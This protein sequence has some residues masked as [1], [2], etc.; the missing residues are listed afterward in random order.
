MKT[1]FQF[2]CLYAALYLFSGYDTV[3]INGIRLADGDGTYQ[4]R[5]E[6][7]IDGVWGTVCDNN[8]DM[9]DAIVMCRM[10]NFSATSFHTGSH[11]GEGVGPVF[12]REFHCRGYESTLQ[13]CTFV[14]NEF[15]CS[16][17]R[18]VGITCTECGEITIA[19]GQVVSVFANGT[20]VTAR[21]D[22]G[23]VSGTYISHCD[24]N[25]K[26][27][28]ITCLPIGYP[29]NI[30][31]IRLV[32]GIGLFDGRVEI[33]INNTWGTVCSY[34][35]RNNEASA[36]CRILGYEGYRRYYT[37]AYTY[38]EGV[39]PIFVTELDCP[40]RATDFNNCTY[41]VN[42]SCTHYSDVAVACTDTPLNITN[43]RLVNGNG[44]YDG[45][46]E[47]MANGVWGTVCSRYVGEEEATTF[48]LMMNRSLGMY[49]RSTVLAAESLPVLIGNMHCS[50][51]KDHINDC[52]YYS[53]DKLYC[54]QSNALSL[55][56]LP[57]S[58]DFMH[59]SITAFD[60]TN[61]TIT[62]DDGYEPEKTYVQCLENGHVIYDKVCTSI[63]SYPLDISSF[64]R[65]GN[66]IE[67]MVEGEWGTICYD[68][69]DSNDGHVIC[70]M[71]GENY[72]SHTRGG[73]GNGPIFIQNLMCTGS[74]SHISEC[75]YNVP[76]NCTHK[77]DVEVVCTDYPLNIS[78]I[79]LA[80]TV[81]GRQ[82][83]VEIEVGGVW[84]TVC[85]DDFSRNDALVI[86]RMLGLN[87]SYSHAHYFGN[88]HYGPGNGTIF[89]DDLSCSGDEYHINDCSYLPEHNCAHNED[90]SVIC[91]ED[92]NVTDARLLNG[93]GPFDGRAEI[94]INDIWGTIC[95]HNFELLQANAFCSILGKR[96]TQR[97]T[98][99]RYG[100]GSGIIYDVSCL[101]M[102]I[103][104]CRFEIADRCTH[105]RDASVV[106]NDCGEPEISH[107]GVDYFTYNGSTLYADCSYYKSYVGTL[108]LLC[109]NDTDQWETVGAC[110]EYSFPLDITGVRL[111]GGESISR[112]R[113]EI[114]SMDTWGTICD[115]SFG[116][117]EADVICS[118]VG[119]PPAVMYYTSAYYGE[120]TGPIFVDELNCGENTS[121]I[122]NCTYNTYDS[123]GHAD[124]IS[125][126]C[127]ECE[128]LEVD[129]GFINSTVNRYGDAVEVSCARDH[130]LNGNSVIICNSDG[131]W[132]DYPTCS[133]I[134]C[135]DP[136]PDHG[137]SNASTTLNGTVVSVECYE[138]YSTVGD[139]IISC[140]ENETWTDETGCEIKDCGYPSVSYAEVTLP[141]NKTTYGETARLSCWT[142]YALTGNPAV[143]CLS[144]GSWEIMPTC[145]IVDCG[146]P[147]P[148]KGSSDKNETTFGTVVKVT[149]DPG[150]NI[151]G[152]STI[153][154]QDDGTWSDNPVCDA[155]DCGLL[156]VPNGKVNDSQGTTIGSV[157][158][159]TCDEGYNIKGTSFATCMDTGTRAYWNFT[160][161]CEIQVCQDPTPDNGRISKTDGNI[162]YVF[163][164]YAEIECNTGY[165]VHG[166]NVI[167]CE[168]DGEWSDNTTCVIFDC[169]SL[170]APLHG[171]MAD[172]QGTKYHAEIRFSCNEDFL[173]LGE[174][175]TVCEETGEW[176][177]ETP[178]CVAK[179]DVGDTCIHKDYCLLADSQCINSVC[180]CITGIYDSRT[181]KCDTMP[182]MPFGEKEGDT[183]VSNRTDCS[184][185]VSFEPRFPIFDQMHTDLYVC[186]YGL[187]SFD[188]PF[189]NPTP[190]ANKQ[191]L[192][193]LGL[194][195]TILAPFYGPIDNKKSGPVWFR[196]YNILNSHRKME[197]HSDLISYIE[198]I[199]KKFEDLPSY[200]ASFVLI[201]TWYQAKAVGSGYDKT[202]SST[203]Q[204]VLTSDGKTTYAFYIYGNGMMQWVNN[205]STDL[206]VWVGY[207][208][209][210]LTNT[211]PYSFTD[212]ALQL[213]LK[214]TIS[215]SEKDVAGLIFRPL[216]SQGKQRDNHAVDCIRWY[217]ENYKEKKRLDYVASLIPDCPCDIRLSRFDP[218]FWRIGLYR[219]RQDLKY[220]C[221]DMLHVGNLGH[222]GKSCCYD[223][224][225]WLWVYERPLAGS[226][227]LFNRHH[228]L[229]HKINDVQP[230]TKCCVLSKYCN[231]YYDLRPTGSCYR[232][233]PYNFG[234]FWG[235][236]HFSTLDGMNFTFNG[237]G[238]YTLL[239]IETENCSFDLQ[240]RTERAIKGNGNL[241]DA[242]VFTAFAA[243]DSHNSSAHIERN[244]ERTGINLY[245]NKV[246]L[247]DK[248]NSNTNE[249]DPFTWSSK[250][251]KLVISKQ[252]GSVNVFFPACNVSLIIAIG[253]EM[254]SLSTFV[255]EKFK[256]QTKGLLGNYN[257]D[258][259]DDFTMPNGTALKPNLTDRDIFEYGKTWT[260]NPN[261]SAFVYD[262][263]G[264]HFDFH[265]DSYVPR[266]LDEAD[267]E[268]RA[269][270]IEVCN[271]PE[272]T[273]CVFDYVFTENPDVAEKTK[274]VKGQAE[275]DKI[276]I[277]ETVPLLEGCSTVNV[278]K[279]QS[280]SC[281][282][283]V[284]VGYTVH[285]VSN[286]VS[287]EFDQASSTVTFVPET[288]EPVSIR[289]AAANENGRYSPTFSLSIL[290]CTDCNGH[291][292]CTG[293]PRNDPRENEYFHY[294]MCECDLEYE[295]P[296]CERV[297]DGC[298]AKPCS[299]DRGCA[300]LTAE[301]QKILK[302]SYIC[303]PCPDGFEDD[304]EDGCID[305]DECS[306]SKG[307]C[308]HNCKNTEG[309]FEC[310]C[311]HGYRV[312][313]NDKLK[314]KDINECEEA[315]HNCDQ[316]CNNT[317]GGFICQCYAGYGFNTTSWSCV[318]ISDSTCDDTKKDECSNTHG[319]TTKD[320]VPL[321]FCKDGH[322]LD[323]TGT[324]CKDIDECSRGICPQDC[325]N[326][327]GSFQ[328]RC[329]AGY[330]LEGVAT[331][332]VC[333]VLHW[334]DNCEQDCICTGQG[335]DRCDPVKGCV[336]EDG[337]HGNRCNDDI[338][339]C[340]LKHQACNDPRKFCVNSL[341]SY[342]CECRA[343]FYKTDQGDCRDTDECPDPLLHNCTQECINAIGGYSCGCR[344]GYTKKDKWSCEDIDECEL[345]TSS[346]EQK[347][348]NDQGQYSC[349]CHFGYS[350]ND[351]RRTCRK[352]SDLCLSIYN[353]TC[354]H[355]CLPD[356]DNAVCGCRSGYKL[357]PDNETCI[358][359]NECTD[360]DENKC[361][362]DATCTNT[363][364]SYLCECPD[365]K[366]LEN[367]GRTCSECDD[368]HYGR[369]CLK[370]CSCLH[371]ICDKRTG[372]VC[373]PGW[374]GTLCD[375]DID[376][377]STEQ[378]VCI[379]EKSVCV[380]VLGSAVCSC[381]TGY[382]NQ[383]GVCQDIDECDD[384]TANE[385]DQ[386]CT[387]TEGSYTCSC[388]HG[389]FRNGKCT[390]INEC[391]GNHGCDQICE[392][393]VGSYRCSCEGG[394][395]L[396]LN[397][398][399][400]CLPEQECSE[401]QSMTCPKHSSCFVENGEVNCR[402]LKGYQ[403]DG[404][405]ND[406][407][408][409]LADLHLCS[410]KCSNTEGSFICSC[411]VGF[412]LLEDTV[413]CKECEMWKYGDNCSKACSCNKHH[414]ETC[415]SVNGKCVCVSGWSGATCNV[416]VNECDD[417][418]VC[419]NNSVCNNTNGSYNCKC[420]KGYY[421]T[422]N[423]E[424]E[425]CTGWTFGDNCM[426]TC[427]CIKTNTETC[428][429]KTGTCVCEE[430]WNGTIC[431]NDINECANETACPKHSMCYN[432]D[433]SYE[434]IC[435]T[436]YRLM[437]DGKCETCPDG[438]YGFNCSEDCAC[439]QLN[440]E[441]CNNVFG[442]CT[443]KEGWIGSTCS[444]DI[445]EC[446]ENPTLCQSK[447][448]STCEN[449]NGSYKCRCNEGLREQ[450]N[451]CT[452]SAILIA[453]VVTFETDLP[454]GTNID[455]TSI[456]ISIANKL[457]TTLR[458]FLKRFTDALLELIITDISVGSVLIANYSVQYGKADKDVASKLVQ[459]IIELQKGVELVFDG[460]TINASSDSYKDMAPCEI[461]HTIV[462][463]CGEG[464]TCQVDDNI[465]VCSSEK[466]QSK[467]KWQLVISLSAAGL[468]IL[469]VAALLAVTVHRLRLRLRLRRR[470]RENSYCPRGDR[471]EGTMKDLDLTEISEG[472]M[473]NRASSRNSRAN[474][475]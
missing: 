281:K 27:T 1:F 356:V 139:N 120:G 373:N 445:D 395:R 91:L 458:T 434:C 336:C 202:K 34:S 459:A 380:N 84:G 47:L 98:G 206:N 252:N 190:P 150:N 15:I 403:G 108:T 448:N 404:I 92:L 51:G 186:K 146:D 200:N 132:S 41:K 273:E 166:D 177:N 104:S 229:E 59:G 435:N 313:I 351:D 42:N 381:E 5:V 60:G 230:K 79:R 216:N 405:C 271:G 470:N 414:T 274:Q 133:V 106:C 71:F 338:N 203:F 240:A 183:S 226:F 18:D 172:L 147:T 319:C 113:V 302:T 83:R 68:G 340:E 85:D 427:I 465:P 31:G 298:A 72:K 89:V 306:V 130:K 266:F 154:C 462:E 94:K 168:A 187:V 263:G 473:S 165:K 363:E 463:S 471:Q 117:N 305:I 425:E 322:E 386:I 339:E 297:F 22:T 234:T 158:K 364:G 215:S 466:G 275:T 308:E 428:D 367:D 244:E 446:E 115:H 74:E 6:I 292:V 447:E 194:Q 388:Q 67:I 343:G 261:N 247:T 352:L 182:L 280:A 238:E 442:N 30:S 99:A 16:H 195:K 325:I 390:D 331:C 397:D 451:I 383:S 228:P 441:S 334:G 151:I 160:G 35:F 10:M 283:S 424:C 211:H 342:T 181:K 375:A 141:D 357:K 185:K 171:T 455:V 257:G 309:S 316:L 260:I 81:S 77:D 64:R 246:D 436:G 393:T 264:S 148:I 411:N 431:E 318:Q 125:V 379:K 295:G 19:N 225:T 421:K 111:V 135:G 384:V 456:Y 290:L 475:F 62:C 116:M 96:A 399:K 114:L 255:P 265:N 184:H 440:S 330:R 277:E 362:A 433:G 63:F 453:V 366:H 474:R 409:C 329:F 180:T 250:D 65:V 152:N 110:R 454:A 438:T 97:F 323:E 37:S 291:G 210:S 423:R 207:T 174:E 457:V 173:L 69:F 344:E 204:V 452:D 365:G 38:G 119:F 20:T 53:P 95:D 112:G 103:S 401:D 137:F 272:N 205:L 372:C 461:L 412:F 449:T 443:C 33:L 345:G 303:E 450:G 25:G 420:L 23:Y 57:C 376:E 253:V 28:P 222:Y 439:N 21:C 40:Y 268:L 429:A 3:N 377:C 11:F 198:N 267:P 45:R 249:T 369:N 208:V 321:C 312:N 355:F 43:I 311:K 144:N 176:S 382:Q 276:E 410:Q 2:V 254:L 87:V 138:G 61:I 213:D 131:S 128:G 400:I 294:S 232:T 134:D 332:T 300:S 127:S 285:I 221:V 460:Q 179:S 415:D 269:K 464:Y 392:N 70:K 48:C 347:C 406:T 358:D 279:G 307:N 56:C 353:L 387:N 223:L 52:S 259:I 227:Q 143:T 54:P 324:S 328:C 288:D 341:G 12:A 217:N 422:G 224:R 102:E 80:S 175:S 193:S 13:E 426:S 192:A 129:N 123:C 418:M 44:S 346:C 430:G 212:A 78:N 444:E 145:T 188:T 157:I 287:A 391:T 360:D 432:S 29:L 8:F 239:Q 258:A 189:A 378:V 350:I 170:T 161:D 162:S 407:D 337:W 36:I 101:D 121:H 394:F 245:G 39:G 348:V 251:G 349:F 209:N 155:I 107:W 153:T 256:N 199:V 389:F 214:L 7:S 314:C 14:P 149:C 4:G 413:T 398:R 310:T 88:A 368:Y 241:S 437:F 159:I 335:A 163:A 32:N 396:S 73:D 317:E 100:Q 58:L 46:V 197:K 286:N 236:P 50:T 304:G 320:N 354:S 299:L 262:D 93:T 468:F 196:S 66:R 359:I 169:G 167:T 191:S 82:G 235:D 361:D 282:V 333:D 156:S 374:A 231:L 220:Q 385:C 118:M 327:N 164:N 248:Y 242:T 416:D 49:Y 233:S 472:T 469:I 218:W 284:D 178:A 237:L 371:G 124:D 24:S 370:T 219:W 142:G 315:M 278:T 55:L 17:E 140:Q 289:V 9:A 109:N 136:T 90:V 467:V 105:E 122:N 417:G 126:V 26:W 270:A 76:N 86:C 201:A 301:Q 293:V 75:T 243:K 326:I 402:C 296:D 408:E 419:P